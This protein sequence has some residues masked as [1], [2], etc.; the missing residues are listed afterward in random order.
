MGR[1]LE[2]HRSRALVSKSEHDEVGGRVEGEEHAPVARHPQLGGE[3]HSRAERVVQ[4]EERLRSCRIDAERGCPRHHLQVEA[5]G[6]HVVE[7]GCF[8]QR[9][10]GNRVY[11]IKIIY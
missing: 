7:L 8:R 10:V 9:P 6:R 5:V 11:N 4:E 3:R 1:H 2:R